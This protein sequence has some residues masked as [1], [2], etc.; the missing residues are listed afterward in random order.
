MT[1][2]S[3]AGGQTIVT[4]EKHPFYVLRKGWVRAVELQQRDPLLGLDGTTTAV[5]SVTSTGRLEKVY[6]L[7]VAFDRTYFVGRRDWGFSVWVHNT[8]SVRL[9]ATTGEYEVYNPQ[10]G[11][12]DGRFKSK[13]K[14]NEEAR[15]ANEEEHASAPRSGGGANG[16]YVN[17]RTNKLVKFDGTLAAD[18]VYPKDLIEQFPDY[19]KLT[20]RQQEFLLNYPGNFEP[21]P[22]SW[23]SSKKNRL[24]DKWAETPMEKRRRRTTLMRS[25]NGSKPLNNMPRA[26]LH[27]GR[28]RTDVIMGG[29]RCD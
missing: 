23:N 24:A 9:N 26:S 16:E 20:Q 1:R 28:D 6:N 22:P 4:T 10:S 18:H 11:R 17:P 3:C 27:S 12:V 25:E 5:E 2:W 14:A 19:D 21:L 15:G 13:A 7:R 29:V 8:Y